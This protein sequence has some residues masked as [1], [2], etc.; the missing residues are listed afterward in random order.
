MSANA[1]TAA[2]PAT[3]APATPAA[4]APATPRPP[5][6]A[7][8]PAGEAEAEGAPKEAQSP[9]ELRVARAYADIQRRDRELKK[10]ARELSSLKEKAERYAKLEQLKESDA[11]AAVRELGLDPFGVAGLALGTPQEPEE[12]APPP[13]REV[14][15]LRKQLEAIQERL[16]ARDKESAEQAEA[17]ERSTALSALRAEVAKVG[18]GELIGVVLEHRG[19]AFLEELAAAYR[20][21]AEEYGPPDREDFMRRAAEH[22]EE[23]YCSTIEAI[24]RSAPK[25]RARLELLLRPA[26]PTDEA[27]PEKKRQAPRSTPSTSARQTGGEPPMVDLA[28]LPRKE[29]M[30]IVRAQAEEMRRQRS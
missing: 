30:R 3:P 1:Q 27:P 25:I 4:P 16:A 12:P 11:L 20:A 15:E 19:D 23:S 14:L 26:E 7:P 13:S 2:P 5:P 18:E 24:V 29:R 28:S 10:Q 22:V 8:P 9:A 6:G 17:R 21:E